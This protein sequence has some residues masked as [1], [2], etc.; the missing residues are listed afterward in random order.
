MAER[1]DLGYED[2]EPDPVEAVMLP[3]EVQGI[4]AVRQKWVRGCRSAIAGVGEP[5]ERRGAI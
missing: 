4:S 3:G 1:L 5:A 2:F